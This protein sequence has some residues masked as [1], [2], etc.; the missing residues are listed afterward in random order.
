M[1]MKSRQEPQISPNAGKYP[2]AK[3][4]VD[5]ARLIQAYENNQPD[6]AMAAQ[7]VLF[8]TSGHRGTSF[9]RSFNRNH[10]LAISQAICFYRRKQN[11]TG[12]LFLGFDTPALA[13]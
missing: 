12:P 4:L 13:L 1:T 5:V 2:E 9:E 6:P 11:M 3:D 10:I 7:K 8:G